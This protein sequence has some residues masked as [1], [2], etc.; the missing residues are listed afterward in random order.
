M[1]PLEQPD[2]AGQGRQRI[3]Q[4]VRQHGQELVL[5]AVR[6][7]QF[8]RVLLE[9]DFQLSPLADVAEHHHDTDRLAVSVADGCA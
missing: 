4:L 6:F 3:A 7:L 5:A 1:Q 9:F 8:A 2:T